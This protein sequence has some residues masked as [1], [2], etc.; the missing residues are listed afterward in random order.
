[1]II[2]IGDNCSV[3][4]FEGETIGLCGGAAIAV[5]FVLVV[6]VLL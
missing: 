4:L 5:L 1:M 6:F 3:T 2:D